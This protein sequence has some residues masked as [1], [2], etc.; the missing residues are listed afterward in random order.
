M[1]SLAL[2]EG[3]IHLG[4]DVHKDSITAGVLEASAMSPVTMRIAT[5]DAA[6]RQLLSKCGELNRVKVSYEAGPTGFTL[7]RTL[8]SWGVACDVVAPS[9]IPKESGDRVK[10]DRRDAASL[11]VLHRAGLLTA[12]HVPAPE[13][14]A[15]RDLAR[16]RADL[17]D[18]LKRV[19]RRL[20]GFLL[21]NG[22]VYRDGKHWTQM[23]HQWLGAQR[24]DNRAQQ[25]TFEYYRAQVAIREQALGAI[26]KDLLGWLERPPIGDSAHRLAA[27]HA[28]GYLGGLVIAAEVA[29]DW[30]RFPAAGSF[31]AFTGLVPS[32]HSSGP[33]RR[34]G[35]ITKTGNKVIRTQLVESALHYR[36]P[37]VPGKTLRERQSHV[38]PATVARATVAHKRLSGRYR[39][40]AARGLNTNVI[41]T[42][43]ARELAG[44]M[45]AEM[46][47]AD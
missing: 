16:A 23:H 46:T 41:N 11:A 2:S 35:G 10:T 1:R 9:R 17:D 32:E 33:S 5:D 20:L 24:F 7:A 19:C 8:W 45:W 40:L 21:R 34:Q 36:R 25:Q 13:I 29:E 43:V 38:G 31:M 30:S 26:N 14:E 37:A 4:L 12:I 15:V 47:A 44:F 28:V 18:D 6:V 3:P 42:A 39:R 22:H 27:Y